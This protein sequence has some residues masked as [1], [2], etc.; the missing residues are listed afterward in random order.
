M[1]AWEP[2]PWR[3]VFDDASHCYMQAITAVHSGTSYNVRRGQAEQI[4]SRNLLKA[5]MH[6]QCAC[7]TWHILSNFRCLQLVCILHD[8]PHTAAQRHV[9]QHVM[10]ARTMIQYHMSGQQADQN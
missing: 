3:L 4:L 2:D 7:I 8:L 1:L 10:S 9:H 6:G 5:R